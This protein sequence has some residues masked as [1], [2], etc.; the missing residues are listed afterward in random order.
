[1]S[2]PQSRVVGDLK[3]KIK[4]PT[5]IKL[6]EYLLCLPR[7]FELASLSTSFVFLHCQDLWFTHQVDLCQTITTIP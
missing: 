6:F 4:L 1:M 7:Q 3:E 2:P 5:L